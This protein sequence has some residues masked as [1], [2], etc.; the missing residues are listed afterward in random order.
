[1][2]FLSELFDKCTSN[3]KTT[4]TVDELELF[5]DEL[6][7]ATCILL[8]EVSKSDDSFDD[9]E[10]EKIISWITLLKEK[11]KIVCTSQY[12]TFS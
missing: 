11:G 5:D 3:K 6:I 7:L 4:I 8:L 9:I 2:K 1:M 10:K 12:I